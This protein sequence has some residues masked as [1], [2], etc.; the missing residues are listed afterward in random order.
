MA[1]KIKLDSFPDKGTFDFPIIGQNL[2]RESVAEITKEWNQ[3]QIE[4]FQASYPHMV[5]GSAAKLE[6]VK[7][8]VE[9]K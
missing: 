9:K 5:E 4:K 8:E 2:T 3:S 6:T 1:L 7:P